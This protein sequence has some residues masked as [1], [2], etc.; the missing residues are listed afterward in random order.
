MEWKALALWLISV[1]RNH[2]TWKQEFDTMLDIETYPGERE[3]LDVLIG[4]VAE[5]NGGDRRIAFEK[6]VRG[7]FDQHGPL[8]L[9]REFRDRPHFLSAV[10]FLMEREAK[11]QQGIDRPYRYPLTIDFIK[12]TLTSKEQQDITEFIDR[13]DQKTLP[14]GTRSVLETKLQL[15]KK[16]NFAEDFTEDNS[17]LKAA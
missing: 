13:S 9:V 12:N 6:F 16:Q 5:K 8:H 10:Y 3:V 2:V 7:Y 1:V 15:P 4:L 14:M 17:L 11:N